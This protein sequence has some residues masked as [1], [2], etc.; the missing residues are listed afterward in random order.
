MTKQEMGLDELKTLR[1]MWKRWLQRD[2]MWAA[3]VV[4]KQGGQTHEL[5]EWTF[6]EEDWKEEFHEMM[7]PYVR[8]LYE[9]EYI[10]E[11]D[12]G[13]FVSFAHILMDTALDAIRLLEVPEYEES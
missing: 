3:E 2:V 11:Q 6:L 4:V 7:Y 1:E 13:E 12:A 8:R 5:D 10:T 9:T